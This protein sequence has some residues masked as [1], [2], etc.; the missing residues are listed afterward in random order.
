MI[1]FS[2]RQDAIEQYIVPALGDFGDDYD[3]DGIFD[4]LFEYRTDRDEDGNWLLTT[5]GFRLII[6][7]DDDQAFGEICARHDISER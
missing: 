7:E 4:E 3:L 2:T 1:T 6:D 5:A